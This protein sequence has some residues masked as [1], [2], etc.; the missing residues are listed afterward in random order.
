[1]LNDRW[2]LYLHVDRYIGTD[3]S[4]QYLISRIKYHCYGV[5]IANVKNLNMKSDET[6]ASLIKSTLV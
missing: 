6:H 4:K 5:H 1:M 3:I 2:G